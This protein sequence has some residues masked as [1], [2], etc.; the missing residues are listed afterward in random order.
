MRYKVSGTSA[1]RINETSGT[2]QNISGEKIE[3]SDS[4]NLPTVLFCIR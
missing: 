3:V 1:I 4:E 2:M